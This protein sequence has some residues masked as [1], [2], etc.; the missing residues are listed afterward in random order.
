MI[1]MCTF[2]GLDFCSHG[3]ANR[4]HQTI[5]MVCILS[6]WLA[7][8]RLL[9]LSRYAYARSSMVLE[10]IYLQNCAMFGVLCSS[11]F[12]HR[13]SH[14]GMQSNEAQPRMEMSVHNG[15][16]GGWLRLNNAHRNGHGLAPRKPMFLAVD[17]SSYHT[18]ISPR[19]WTK[20][21]GWKFRFLIDSAN[22]YT[23]M[24]NRLAF[25][26][27][28]IRYSVSIRV[29]FLRLSMENHHVQRTFPA[30]LDQNHGELPHRC[31][32][33]CWEKMSWRV[34]VRTR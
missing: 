34:V 25:H 11:I 28:S 3:I 23:P 2:D 29:P 24:M 16:I 26:Q 27:N 30:G 10:Y 18:T 13:G 7:I 12:Q 5:I 19:C 32:F 20:S 21:I 31:C 33:W 4:H 15:G 8:P 1:N 6:P 9:G 22:S 17:R 14:L